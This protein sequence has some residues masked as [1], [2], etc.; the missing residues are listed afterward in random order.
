MLHLHPD[1][2]HV[3]IVS[4]S[5]LRDRQYAEVF[6]EELTTFGSRVAFTW[7]TDL[8]MDELR[9][10]LS[11]L[12]DHTVVLYLTMFQ[13][14]AGETFTPRQ[15][16]DVFAPA[17]R[18]PIY[19]YYETY[20]GHGIVGGSIVTF[21]EIGRK[22]AQ[23]GLRILSGEDAQAAARSESYQP[24]TIFDGRQLRRWKISEQQLP[25]GSIVRFKEATYWEQY[26]WTIVA[27][28]SLCLLEALLI[29][30][31]LAQLRRRRVAEASVRENE[32]RMSLAV[33]AANFGIWIRD[34]TRNEIWATGKW[35]ELF[36]FA[37]SERLDFDRILQRLHPDD[38]EAL[39]Q[40]LPEAVAGGGSYETEFRLLLP[41]GRIRWISS[42]GRVEFNG[43]GKPVRI[44]GASRDIT[45]H[46]QAEQETQLL[47]QEIAHVGRVSMMGQ[48]ASALA[49]EI[50]QPLGAILRN[51]EAAE[52][53]MQNASPDLDEIRA[54]LADIRKDDQRA[55]GVIDRMRGL[56]KRHRSRYAAAR[57]GR[58]R[59]RSRCP[60]AGRCCC[61]AGEA[62]RGRAGRS[63]AR[64]W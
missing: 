31:L 3:A 62:G 28:L 52:L 16:L 11:R 5:G 21:E 18:A 43:N 39:R 25:P 50:N 63:A 17:S 1:A 2:R 35:R 41:D 54:I 42:Q 64:A 61:A 34:L 33:D 6:R 38:C 46:K 30:A 20:V 60:C 26:H 55:G 10:E 8:S 51:A 59:W 12:P 29:V 22:A 48:L 56:L 36:G 24:V 4:G 49:H 23:L 37:P 47:R 40:T 7:L 58:T 44:R 45:A 57:R 27:A 9:G 32:H 15:A 13:D 14:A 53:F 19:G